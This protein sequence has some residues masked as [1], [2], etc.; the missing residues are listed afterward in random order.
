MAATS[1]VDALAIES[2]TLNCPSEQAATAA[3]N[4][5]PRNA[6]ANYAARSFSIPSHRRNQTAADS[7]HDDAEP[8]VASAPNGLDTATLSSKT[9]VEHSKKTASVTASTW[10]TAPAGT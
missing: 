4:G 5:A 6:S 9:G 10:C 3:E 8:L 1:C 2:P 7:V